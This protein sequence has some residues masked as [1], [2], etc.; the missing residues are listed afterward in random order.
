MDIAKNIGMGILTGTW[1]AIQAD[2]MSQAGLAHSLASKAHPNGCEGSDVHQAALVGLLEA[3]ARFDPLRGNLFSTYATWWI[4]REI[5]ALFPKACPAT[6]RPG[7]YWQ[8]LKAC[9]T[10][11]EDMP[12]ALLPPTSLDAATVGDEGNGRTLHDTLGCEGSQDDAAEVSWQI[13]ALLDVARML[14]SQARNTPKGAEMLRFRLNVLA[15]RIAPTALGSSE[16]L[17][18]DAIGQ[19]HETGRERARQVEDEVLSLVRNRMTV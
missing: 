12:S 13:A 9:R 18:L 4:Q 8:A 10:T 5:K 17:T 7:A 6:V 14:I 15:Y 11:G 3:V 1:A 2:P 19:A 16:P